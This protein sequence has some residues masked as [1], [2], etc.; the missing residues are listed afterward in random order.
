[1]TTYRVSCLFGRHP[2]IRRVRCDHPSH[3]FGTISQPEHGG[4]GEALILVNQSLSPSTVDLRAHR[5]DLPPPFATV[6]R[7]IRTSRAMYR[8][9]F[10]SFWLCRP[11]PC[12]FARGVGRM[13]AM[14]E[15]IAAVMGLL[16]A[17]IFLAH[18]FE[19]VRWA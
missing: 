14:F 16:G 5:A 17:G 1:M 7:E 6:L 3:R 11:V 8:Q 19:G 18:V 2:Q 15:T 12:L 4:N 9:P 10:E 13:F